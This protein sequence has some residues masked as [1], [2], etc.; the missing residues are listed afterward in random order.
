MRAIVLLLALA[1]ATAVQAQGQQRYVYK[2][3]DPDGTVHYTALPP[4]G[5][6]AQRIPIQVAP[7]SARRQ[8]QQPS[9][10]ASSEGA[11][12]SRQVDSKGRTPEQVAFLKQQCEAARNNIRALESG[13]TNRRFLGPDGKV[14]RFTPEER[15]AEIAENQA[16]LDEYCGEF[17]R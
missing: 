4:Q 14:I 15:D 3:S 9:G 13:G 6:D 11:R 7:E 17:Q 16:Y 10:S 1:L 2:W 5:I 12:D 8:V